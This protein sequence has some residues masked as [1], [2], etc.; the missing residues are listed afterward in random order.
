M[1]KV[2]KIKEKEKSTKIRREGRQ[3]MEGRKY[4]KEEQEDRNDNDDDDDNNNNNN[5]SNNNNNNNN[6]THTQTSKMIK[7]RVGGI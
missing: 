7:R 5:N 6:K 1:N 3:K 2:R 4:T